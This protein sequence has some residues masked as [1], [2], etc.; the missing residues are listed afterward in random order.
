MLTR[1]EFLN[2]QLAHIRAVFTAIFPEATHITVRIDDG[3]MEAIVDVSMPDIDYETSGDHVPAGIQSYCSS[4]E[5]DY[6]SF[7]TPEGIE[8]VVF[9]PASTYAGHDLEG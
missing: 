6:Y 4:L 2:R 3:E 1:D 8:A 7:L 9:P 5:D